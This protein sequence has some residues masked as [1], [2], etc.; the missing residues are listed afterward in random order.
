VAKLNEGGK[1]IIRDANKDIA[2]K[3]KSTELTERLST[4]IGFNKAKFSDLHFMSETLI[5]KIA[6]DNNMKLEVI[7]ESK[8]LSNRVYVMSR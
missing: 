7:S 6:Q 8:R 1:I 2:E 5:R 3:H 4:G